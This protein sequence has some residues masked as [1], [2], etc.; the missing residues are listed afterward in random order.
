M[1]DDAA[2]RWLTYRELGRGVR[3]TKLAIPHGCWCPKAVQGRATHD[4]ALFDVQ[5]NGHD[6]THVRALVQALDSLREQLTKAEQRADRAERHLQKERGR[7]DEER[8]RVDQL[9]AALADAVAAERIA[10]GVAAGL[11]AE[12]ERLIV[13]SRRPWW[14][15]WFA[16]AEMT[17]SNVISITPTSPQN[18]GG[19]LNNRSRIIGTTDC[20]P[21]APKIG[22]IALAN[23][24]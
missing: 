16:T 15:S 12:I 6:R 1:S 18:I 3:R 20:T 13:E 10:S 2:E 14:R 11:R 8:K 23:H 17:I 5:P 9:Q 22:N 19:A 21:I 24:S 4:A 7:V